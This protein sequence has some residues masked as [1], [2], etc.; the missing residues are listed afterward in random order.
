MR[1]GC[2]LSVCAMV[3]ALASG[4]GLRTALTQ[5]MGLET[6]SE[7]A[8]R[9]T[10]AAS[11]SSASHGLASRSSTRR[12]RRAGAGAGA[13]TSSTYET[14][15]TTYYGG[16]TAGTASSPHGACGGAH[17]DEVRSSLAAIRGDLPFDYFPVAVSQQMM[18]DLD[19]S[20]NVGTAVSAGYANVLHVYC[21]QCVEF[22]TTA[23]VTVG[24]LVL[25]ICPPG[26]ANTA[27]CQTGGAANSVG[28]YNH[29][30][31]FGSSSTDVPSA[32]GDNPTGTVTLVACP[33]E[34]DSMMTTLANA[35]DSQAGAV[36]NWYYDG[37]EWQGAYGMSKWGC[38]ECGS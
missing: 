21:G 14:S 3:A 34:L 16:D 2:V 28:K 33:S 32:I 20:C 30:D 27:W 5:E 13:S 12:G 22:T 4:G 31:I 18:E 15:S 8:D 6:A 10:S 7:T 23:G 9:A 19:P 24:G 38:A 11:A 35:K 36:C 25:D 37:V 26:S 29:L 17:L 1:V